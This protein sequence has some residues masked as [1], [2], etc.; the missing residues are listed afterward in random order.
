MTMPRVVA[1]ETLDGLAEDDP[2]A[3]RSRRDLQRVHRLMGT[4]AIVAR[5]LGGLIAG[6]SPSEPLR[7]LELG[8]GD[9]T[10][11]LGVAR[12][13][14]GDLPTVHMQ[15]LDRQNLISPA[16]LARYAALGWQ[17]TARVSDVFDWMTDDSQEASS[18][19][20]W[21][22]IVA[23]LFIHH[24]EGAPLAALLG[25]IAARS[26][27]F[28][29]CEPRRA[30]LALVGSHLVGL[31]GANAVTREDAVLSVH[32]G[33]AQGEITAMWPDAGADWTL[34]DASAGLFSQCFCASRRQPA[35]R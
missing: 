24:F 1:A 34:S 16:T 32:A 18:A 19:P 6:R 28:L 21:D 25:A 26:N 3:V 13:L 14:G 20:R 5:A 8:A 23:N 4:R 31:V 22:V 30:M 17:A 2:A 9:G 11:M 35:A 33:F 15:L 10:L 12:S 29:A 7:V 27:S